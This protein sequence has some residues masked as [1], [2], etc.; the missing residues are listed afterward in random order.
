MFK[1]ATDTKTK[2]K[3]NKCKTFLFIISQFWSSQFP[4]IMRWQLLVFPLFAF[5]GLA[6]SDQD[7]HD[8]SQEFNQCTRK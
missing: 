8:V 5:A 3:E 4:E 6:H 7:C 1:T 2:T